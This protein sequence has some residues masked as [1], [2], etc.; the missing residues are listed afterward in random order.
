MQIQHKIFLNSFVKEKHSGQNFPLLLHSCKN[1]LAIQVKCQFLFQNRHCVIHERGR[2]DYGSGKLTNSIKMQSM[3]KQ[4]VSQKLIKSLVLI[5]IIIKESH[6]FK[7][8]YFN[9]C[10][11][12]FQL[13]SCFGGYLDGCTSC[14]LRLE[15]LKEYFHLKDCLFQLVLL[16]VQYLTVEK[17]E[18]NIEKSYI[19]LGEDPFP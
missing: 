11:L 19:C 13:Q 9:C 15:Q 6:N 7:N 3:L 8:T 18:L 2:K 10:W 12:S 17:S 4:G 14:L 16:E 1:P 5:Q